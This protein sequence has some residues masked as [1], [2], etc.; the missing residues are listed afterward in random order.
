MASPLDALPETVA[1][2]LAGFVAAA[3]QAFAEHLVSL[4]LFGS[5]AEGRL[6]STSDV[7]VIVVLARDDPAG[8]A[9]IGDAYGLA[10]AAIRLSAMFILETEIAAANER[11]LP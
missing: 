9:T 11:P 4:A 6:R 1:A 5:A 3:Q 8:L 10:R 2:G 7:N